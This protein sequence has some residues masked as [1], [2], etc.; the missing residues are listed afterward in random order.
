M[1]DLKIINGNCYID[2]Q[3]I[4]T[5]IYI[6][7]GK[8]A[9]IGTS[10]KEAK[11]TYDAKGR[12]VL[13][14]LIDPHVHFELD[15]GFIKSRDDFHTGPV[16]CAYGGITTF[17]DFLQPVSNAKDLQKAYV[18]RRKQAE[19]SVV[20]YKF[21]ATVANPKGCVD[22]IVQ[23]MNEL[24]IRSVKLFTTYSD[25][26]RRTYDDEIKQL[27]RLSKIND[28]LV[29]AHVE[30]DD[31]IVIKD[32][33]QAKDL[34]ISRPSMSETKEALH[35]AS[36]VQK[37]GGSLYMVHT[38]S[39]QTIHALKAQYNDILNK[40]FTIESCP[41]YFIFDQ[42]KFS[43]KDG[44]LY[45]MAPP[46]RS[47]AEQALLIAHIDDVFTIGTDHCSFNRSDKKDKPLA[48][49]PLGIAGVEQSFSL[50][51]TMF[52][53]KIIN[54]MSKNVAKVHHLYPRKGVIKEGSDADLFIYD[55]SFM[56]TIDTWHNVTD[57]SVYAGH[58]VK[59]QVISTIVGGEFV[60]KD[61]TLLS[62]QGKYV[63]D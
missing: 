15:L 62:H 19:P 60:L 24:N 57:Y 45:T 29:L 7:D 52:G 1:Y 54:K 30:D 56:R 14:G 44:Y 34:P 48:K 23:K 27:L 40:K 31:L 5:S 33:Y 49:M 16:A 59:G 13:P 18:E 21:H 3:F 26:N 37:T 6:K 28:F 10:E 20:D 50:M 51:Y 61:L 9:F 36:L 2:D 35:L 12:L 53:E 58:K 4:K 47:Q 46:L 25:S 43:E 39:G 11:D 63:G 8:I 41:H 22:D 32:S 42:S 38:T 17:I 55:D